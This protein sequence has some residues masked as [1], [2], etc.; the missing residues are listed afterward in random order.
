MLLFD[1]SYLG[2]VSLP[3]VRACDG[4]ATPLASHPQRKLATPERERTSWTGK[5]NVKPHVPVQQCCLAAE[6]ALLLLKKLNEAQ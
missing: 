4:D 3:S 5:T 2:K 1:C 6:K